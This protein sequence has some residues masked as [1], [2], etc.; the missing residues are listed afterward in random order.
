MIDRNEDFDRLIVTT[1]GPGDPGSWWLVDKKA[2]TARDL[3]VSYAIAADDIGPMRMIRY[4]AADGLEIAGV[5]TLPPGREAKKLPVIVMPHDGPRGR[6]YPVFDWWVQAFASR[7]YAVFQPNFR[8]SG[9][10]GSAFVRAGWGEFGRRMQTDMSD[11]LAEIA[12]QGIVDPK[13]ACI[14]GGGGYGGYAAL[15]GVTLQQGVYQCAVSIAGISD[16]RELIGTSFRESGNIWRLIAAF[17]KGVGEKQDGGKVSPIEFAASANAPVMLIH[18]A[19]DIAVPL[20]Q[21]ADM[22]AA[23]I[24]ARKPAEFV[25]VAGEEHSPSLNSMRIDILK[26]AVG[27][28]EKYNPPDAA[29]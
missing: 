20:Q 11:G 5:L 6:S 7:G 4:K 12:R 16:V 8:G 3:S 10:S 15:A 17:K 25:K 19:D 22:A 13:R 1:S 14:V 18:R 24:K 2:G 9:G 23:L 27:F 29:K 26:A 28:V 21:S